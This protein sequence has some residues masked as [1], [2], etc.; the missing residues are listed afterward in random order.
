MPNN[1]A[2]C[3]AGDM[4]PDEV[5]V[6]IDKYF[7]TWKPNPALSRPEYPA[8]KP[9]TAIKDSTVIGQEAERLMMAWRFKNAADAQADTL[10]VYRKFSP[11]AKPDCLR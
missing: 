3:M 7:G 9:L 4:N 10:E 6:L 5:I 2:I 11:T 8:L 1:T